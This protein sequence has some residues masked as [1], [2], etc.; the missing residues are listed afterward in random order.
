MSETGPFCSPK[1]A[2]VLTNWSRL[3]AE[4][5]PWSNLGICLP[6]PFPTAQIQSRDAIPSPFFCLIHFFMWPQEAEPMQRVWVEK[7]KEKAEECFPLVCA[8]VSE[9]LM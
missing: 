9:L 3:V 1:S 8:H 6:P 7:G 5:I 4:V 2:H